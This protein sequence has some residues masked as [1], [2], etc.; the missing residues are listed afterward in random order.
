MWILLALIAVGMGIPAFYRWAAVKLKVDR[1]ALLAAAPSLPEARLAKW[2]EFGAPQI[3]HALEMARFS[4]RQ[5]WYVTHVVAPASSSE[6]PSIYGID[7]SKLPQ[8]VARQDGLTVLVVLAAPALLARDV[9][10]GD[11][12]LGVPVFQADASVPDGREL[13][14]KRLVPYLDYL[15]RGLVRDIPGAQIVIEVGGLKEEALGSQ[16]TGRDG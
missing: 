6:P 1:E 8:D 4:D 16:G 15:E 11:R 3:H 13:A 2:L 7:F 10:V 5:P 12:A 14:L 9:L